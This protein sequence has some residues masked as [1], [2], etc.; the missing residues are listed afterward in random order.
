MPGGKH[1][2]RG[3]TLIELIVVIILVGIISVTA[4]S[5][6]SGRSSFDAFV[7][8]DQAIAIVR[9]IQITAMQATGSQRA[10]F[11]LKV[12]SGTADTS[13]CMGLIT[14]TACPARAVADT[15]SRILLGDTSR[16]RFTLLNAS[17]NTLYFDLLGR[18]VNSAGERICDDGCQINLQSRDN[19][20]LSMCI[21]REGFIDEGGCEWSS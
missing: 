18:P 12:I 11:P 10:N 1:N 14:G 8:R 19:N 16:V 13:S 9:Q 2:Q 3:F 21:N 5:Q 20:T 6:M 17:A 15:S 7:T 4:A